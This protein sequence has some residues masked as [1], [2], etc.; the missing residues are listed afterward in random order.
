[1]DTERI[2]EPLLP[3]LGQKNGAYQRLWR[4]PERGQE[5]H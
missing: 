5:V 1:M 3:E 2:F 4:W